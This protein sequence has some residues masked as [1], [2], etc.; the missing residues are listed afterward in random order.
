[1]AAMSSPYPT[2]YRARVSQLIIEDSF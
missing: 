2:T 1:V